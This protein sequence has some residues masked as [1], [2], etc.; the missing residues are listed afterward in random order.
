MNG[1]APTL[2]G[3]FARAELNKPYS[4]GLKLTKGTQ[5]I[6]WS[7]EG[8]LPQGLTLD[9]NT[10]IIYGTPTSYGKNGS[11]KIKVTAENSAGSKT[12]TVTLKVK[13]TAPRIT[14]SKLPNAAAGQTYSAELSATGSEPITWTANLPEYLTLDGS[15]ISGIVPASVKSFKITVYASNPVK[16]KVKKNYTVKVSAKKSSLNAYNDT[17]ITDNR[18]GI[19]SGT[20]G[21]VPD[22]SERDVYSYS[23]G[24]I[25]VAELGEISCDMAGMY[26]FEIKLPDYVPEGSEL[27][28][29]ANSDKPSED[30]DIAEFYDEAGVEISAVPENR[31]IIISIWLNAGTGYNP[32]IAV[33][34]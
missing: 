29:F 14:T 9:P 1:I 24:V 32:V 20:S 22:L 3:S 18:T 16:E 34:H 21:S 17:S 6:V 11:F 23:R 4:S 33:K 31:R 27:V 28:Y 25:I 10:G 2:S 7:I 19:N 5:P 12:K 13:G 30:D 26:D 8:D 15:T